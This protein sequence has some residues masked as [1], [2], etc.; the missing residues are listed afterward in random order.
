MATQG[1]KRKLTAILSADVKGYSRLMGEDEVETVRTLTASREVMASLI[2]QFRGRVVDS[3]GDNV[4][5]EFG[6]VVDAVQCAVEIQ[7]VL[8]ARNAELP[9][10]RRMEFR[11][12][13][14]LGDVIE[15]AE[16]IY[17]DGVNIAARVEGLAE[18]GGICIS[19]NAHEQIEDKLPLKYEYL[20]KHRVK[21]I[22]KPVRVY[23]A[24]IEAEPRRER[25]PGLRRWQWAT[26]GV[27]AA[28]VVGVGALAIWYFYLR[29]VPPAVEPAS[30]DRMAFPLPEKPSIA[31]LP[32]EDLSDDPQYEYFSDGLTEQIITSLS[33]IPHLFVI[34]RNS[35]FIY[36]GKP[37]KV[38]QVS[39]ELGV[40]YV[41]EGSV[42]RTADRIRITVQLIDAT[43]GHHL[44]A[45]RYD[46]DL[47]DIF[48]IQ[49]QITLKIMKA[50]RVE[51][52]LGKEGRELYKVTD[53]L[54][55]YEKLIQGM[56][57]G[58]RGTKHDNAQ[59]R[60]L[61]EQAIALDPECARCYTALG[62]THFLD[63]RFGWSESRAKSNNMAFELA[64]KA[65][66]LDDKVAISHALLASF[67]VLKRD[68]E[69]AIAEAERAVALNPN[70]SSSLT[71]LAASLSCSGRWEEG[72][73][74]FKKAIRLNPFPPIFYFHFLGRNYMM[75][76]RYQ[77]AI[78]T[79][80]RALPVNPDY[81]PVHIGLAA[82]YSLSGRE[83]EARAAA[84]EVLRI[85][86]RFNL[87][88]YA[89]TLPYEAQAE[90]AALREAGLPEHPPLPLPDKPSIAVLP[91]DNMSGDPE[92]EYFSDGLTEQTISALSKVPNL[93]VIARNSTFTYK[94]KPVK[95]QQV[96]EELGV[97]YV[98]EGSVRKAEDRVRIT[99]QLIDAL[100]GHHLWSE[101]YDRDLKD[102]FAIQDEITMKIL[103]AMQVKL[104]SGE[105]ARLIGKG[106]KNIKAY[107]KFLEGYDQ[108]S[109]WNKESIF[110]AKQL[111]EEAIA[112][113]PDFGLAY[114]FLGYYHWADATYG[115]SKS[116][117]ESMQKALELAEKAF[118]LDDSQ[119]FS[120]SLISKIYVFQ[121]QHAKAIA[122]AKQAVEL[123]P[124][125]AETVGNLGWIL[126]CAGR[127]EEGIPLLKKQIRLDPI[128]HVTQFDILGRAYFLA[129]RYEEAITEYKKAVKVAPD[130]RDAHVGLAST[131]A[132]L[133]RKEEARAEAE[134]IVRIDPNFSIQG[135]TDMMRI[136]V[137]IEP[138]IEG[139]R[140]A[141]LPD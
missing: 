24:Q 55:A 42:Q 92:Q 53:N 89:R 69:N 102:I 67:H 100:T 119:P 70:C 111:F 85:N 101:T 21:N 48:A 62:W 51:L 14:N 125:F 104:T 116:P 41:L 65:L 75:T 87:E 3:P 4:L 40:R 72:I 23:R 110:R 43:T 58:D 1:V 126:R 19:G 17:G 36:K 127:P 79:Y 5:A 8:K 124:N 78:A 141:G 132:V 26:L 7:R 39:E 130:Y 28:L 106:T 136:Q 6:S 108:F 34:A 113:D 103:T 54:E 97:R 68:W 117:P 37:V 31:V 86:P 46:R 57:Y 56:Y 114:C 94:G 131:Y 45:G 91:F 123:S 140:K 129:G 9:E 112:L 82:T 13:V 50:M 95:V 121:G 22:T 59:A 61:F 18:A 90:L 2:E 74:L 107:L 15:E 99:V 88:S 80:K 77:E 35:T 60:Q 32:F 10:N 44:W 71:V 20:G 38:Q 93:F 12:G 137:G 118:S 83:E 105:Q 30:V 98:L 135:Y 109:R 81:L 120:Y 49:D 63:A 25:R 66:A 73:P 76:G 115:W 64:Q 16:R 139:L 27:L 122:K 84:A 134:E 128:P 52:R 96:A 33:N 138:E 11:I 133:G 29:P 47:E